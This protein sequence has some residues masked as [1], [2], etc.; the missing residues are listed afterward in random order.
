MAIDWVAEHLAGGW[1]GVM[2]ANHALAIDG[3]DRVRRALGIVEVA[4]TGRDAR[5]DGRHP[6]PR[7]VDRGGRGRAGPRLFAEGFEVPL[8]T[9]PVRAARARPDDEPRIVSLRISAAPYNEPPDYDA[10]AAVLA[11]HLRGPGRNVTA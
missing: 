4:G 11:R 10:L 3:R 8:T 5:R 7:R 9:W 2:A 6:A 1:P